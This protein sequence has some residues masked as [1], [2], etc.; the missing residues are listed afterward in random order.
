V[1]TGRAGLLL[2]AA[3]ALAGCRT[4]APSPQLEL[5]I[6]VDDLPVHGPIPPGDTA[7]RITDELV[8]ALRAAGA[9]QAVGF[10]NGHWTEQQ[11]QT[12]SVLRAWRRAGLPIAN[13]GWAHLSAG[14]L[15]PAEFERELVRGEPLLRSLAGSTDWRWFRYPFLSEGSSPA[16]RS[17]LRAILSRRGYRIAAVTMDFS[18][19]RFTAPYARCLA[20]NDRGGL[21]RLESLYLEAA[22]R[23]IDRSRLLSRTVHGRDI[24]YVLLLH[25]SAFTARMAPRLLDLYRRRGF[26]FVSLSEAEADP[27]Y[28]TDVDPAKD[29]PPAT[30]EGRAAAKALPVPP[31]PIDYTPVD[32]AC[33]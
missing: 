21:A 22:G 29:G 27:A 33:A 25:S 31:P 10:V 12:L 16:H 6:T 3:A 11:P 30:L 26:R 5:A 17:A 15:T 14:E 32:R 1:K 28:A 18:D 4:A 23:A 8:A 13:H 7:G 20:K 9:R 24:P 19:W 2:L